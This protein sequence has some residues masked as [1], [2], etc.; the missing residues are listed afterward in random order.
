MGIFRRLFGKSG[1]GRSQPEP[2]PNIV[3][4]YE[5]LSVPGAE[6]VATCLRLRAEGAGRIT[7]VIL[8][9]PK[10]LEPLR[11]GIV[12][13]GSPQTLLDRTEGIDARSFLDTRLAKDEEYYRSVEIGAW[14][15]NVRASQD[16][17]GPTDSTMKPRLLRTV[18]ICNVP[19][20]R[21]WE[22]PAYL[23][24]GGW[25]ECPNPEEHVALLRYWHEHY[26]ADV[27][28]LLGDAIECTVSRPPSER[29]AALALAREQFVYSPDI[30]MQGTQTL[31][32]LA[33]ALCGGT[34]WFFWWD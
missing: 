17:I 6:A 13:G 14:P 9:A 33:A 22:V 21:S 11:E 10:Y 26:G 25:N 18:V 27:I 28:T 16:L 23:F 4:P 8:G 30:V 5:T 20:P 7:P 12:A 15:D 29:E 24:F 2:E 1:P 32:A 19:T 3:L 31:S 34:T